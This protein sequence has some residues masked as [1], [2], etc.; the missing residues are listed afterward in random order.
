MSVTAPGT[1]FVAAIVLS[2]ILTPIARVLALRIGAVDHPGPISAHTRPAA[3]TGGLAIWVAAFAAV[4]AGA[5]FGDPSYG[6]NATWL[7]PVTGATLLVAVG[8]VDDVRRLDPRIKLL[9][10]LLVAIAV[11]WLSGIVTLTGST[12]WDFLISVGWLTVFPQA[13]N[14]FDGLDGLAAGCACL[15]LGFLG[16]WC[17]AIGNT[18]IALAAWVLTGATLGFLAY[19]FPPSRGIFLGDSGSLFLGFAVAFLALRA[20]TVGRGDAVTGGTLVPLFFVCVPVIE[21]VF[22]VVRR[23]SKG[24]SVLRG[25]RLHLYDAIHQRLRSMRAVAV[26]YYVATLLIAALAW[27]IG[28]GT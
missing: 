21:A 1:A 27:W 28:S 16:A 15:G 13:F 12:T 11:S 25:D 23:V 9:A 17:F 3:R 18:D 8:L 5:V 20:A 6:F 7:V 22:V 24:Y 2:L 19:N 26:V 10:G 14:A 4:G